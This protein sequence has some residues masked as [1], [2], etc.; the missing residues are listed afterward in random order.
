[1]KTE[2][3]I[4]KIDA[5]EKGYFST[6][7]I[8]QEALL[9]IFVQEELLDE[10]WCTPMALRELTIGYLYTNGYVDSMEQLGKDFPIQQEDE[11]S[12]VVRLEIRLNQQRRAMQPSKIS[13]LS[14]VHPGY[15]MACMDALLHASEA[16]RETGCIHAAGLFGLYCGEGMTDMT[17]VTPLYSGEDISRYYALYKAVG[18]ALLSGTELSE[19]CLC[20][21]GRLPVGYMERVV[22]TGISCVISR[23]A[24]TDAALRLAERYGILTC[25]F[26][27]LK[28]MNLYPTLTGYAI[29]AGGKASR[30][31]GIDKSQLEVKG[32]TMLEH[33][34]EQIPEDRM[35][36]LSYNREPAELLHLGRPVRLVKDQVEG[37][38]PLGGIYTILQTAAKDG[39]VRLLFVACDLPWYN[40]RVTEVLLQET[41]EAADAVVFKTGD[42]RV[43]PL[44]GVYRMNCL[45]VIEQL[46]EEKC[47]KL[48]AL[49]DRVRTVYLETEQLGLQDD[50]FKNV[51][52]PADYNEVR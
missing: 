24:P 46:L 19:L 52:T 1:M 21:T 37:I 6:D 25:G 45:P 48:Q 34:L 31:N 5:E 35:P 39:F 4:V 7:I 2:R 3:M 27:S 17:E 51:N 33:I 42:G 15:R 26:A 20:T 44:C 12:Y 41:A 28:R 47:Y 9:R 8:A 30:F 18:A 11:G 36:Y 38:G 43:H 10:L 16:F 13:V 49:L 14:M 29:L 40:K 50:W 23:S 22:R 32:R